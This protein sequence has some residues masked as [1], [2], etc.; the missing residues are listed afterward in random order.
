MRFLATTLLVIPL[1]FSL[2]TNARE[3]S[4]F[5]GVA[6][7]DTEILD[8][9]SAGETSVAEVSVTDMNLELGW[10]KNDR[11]PLED[12]NRSNTVTDDLDDADSEYDAGLGVGR[13]YTPAPGTKLKF[14]IYI[15]RYE[16]N[17]ILDSVF[18]PTLENSVMIGGTFM[19]FLNEDRTGNGYRFTVGWSL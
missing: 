15:L 17:Q 12:F 5:G 8:T 7:L 9:Q 3:H 18:Q 6:L 10:S 11:D 14:N 4:I 13:W 19:Y 2:S 1:A 16:I